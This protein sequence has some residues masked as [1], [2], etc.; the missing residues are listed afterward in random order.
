MLRKEFPSN[1]KSRTS[2]H[3]QMAAAKAY[4]KNC[5]VKRYVF[6]EL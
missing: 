1:L 2:P 5:A 6:A 4:V 3:A